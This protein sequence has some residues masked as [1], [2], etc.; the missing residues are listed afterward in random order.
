MTYQERSKLI[1]L[2]KDN[3]KKK[4]NTEKKYKQRN[5]QQQKY[6]RRSL[7]ALKGKRDAK[8][9]KINYIYVL[10]R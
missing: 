9:E 4:N 1:S 2:A 8:R 6:R 3:N 7:R 10:W 5:K